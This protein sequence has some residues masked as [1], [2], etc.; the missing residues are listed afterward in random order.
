ML[1]KYLILVVFMIP[2]LSKALVVGADNGLSLVPV[3][4]GTKVQLGGPL[5]TNNSFDLGATSTY[6]VR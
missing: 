2:I 6:N 3:T 4:G 1:R 5:V